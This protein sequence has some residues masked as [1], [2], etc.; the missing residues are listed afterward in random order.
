MSHVRLAQEAVSQGGGGQGVVGLLGRRLDQG[1]GPGPVQVGSRR[2]P[3]WA[4]GS[5]C[6]QLSWGVGLANSASAGPLTAATAAWTEASAEQRG[7]E[8]KALQ[9]RGHLEFQQIFYDRV[10]ECRSAAPGPGNGGPAGMGTRP[11]WGRGG[12]SGNTSCVS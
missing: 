10:D 4:S 8:P 6:A 12:R 9:S 5:T 3:L 1:Q 2:S 11:A 7:T